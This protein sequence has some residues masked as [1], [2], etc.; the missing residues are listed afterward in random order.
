MPIKISG[1]AV[2]VWKGLPKKK[3]SV[4]NLIRIDRD[5][6]FRFNRY[7]ILIFQAPL[8]PQHENFQTG[9]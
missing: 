5:P 6:F 2:T 4:E 1:K 3:W 8:P 9:V 7:A